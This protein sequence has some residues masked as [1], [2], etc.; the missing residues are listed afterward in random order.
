[1]WLGDGTSAD[2]VITTADKEIVIYLQ[3]FAMQHGLALQPKGKYGWHLSQGLKGNKSLNPIRNVLKEYNLFNNKHIP[4]IFFC[5]S[6]DARL[7]LL[8]GLIDSDG[9]VVRNCCDITQ[10][11]QTLAQDIVHLARSL[12]MHASITSCFKRATNG[13]PRGGT[14]HRIGLSGPLMHKIP[15]LLSRKKCTERLQ[16]KRVN[17]TGFTMTPGG[18]G[19][20][21]ELDM[22]GDKSVLLEDF[23]IVTL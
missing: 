8:A 1:M 4:A 7:K 12:G 9:H 18:T 23:T 14:Y 17:V 16:C 13:D 20:V 15:V 10:K 3:Q 21:C 6:T 11:N 19:N 2:T 5:S 22:Q